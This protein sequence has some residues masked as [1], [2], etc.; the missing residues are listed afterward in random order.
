MRPRRRHLLTGLLALA[1]GVLLLALGRGRPLPAEPPVPAAP[2]LVR[3]AAFEPTEYRIRVRT[4]GTVA[5]RTESDL[6]AE[7]AGRVVWASSALVPGGFFEQGE[8]LLEVD[9]RD[10][11]N[12]VARAR[13][14]R[15]RA[16]SEVDLAALELERQL[17]LAAREIAS[18]S[19]LE[20]ARNSE[21]VARA[22]LAEATAQ[23]ERARRDL[24]RT[25][26][27]APFV[28]RVRDKRVD[29]GQFV[30]RGT[31]IARVYAVDFAEVRL[32][33]HDADLAFLDLPIGYR[34][35]TDPSDGPE[36]RLRASFAGRLHRWHARVVRTE[37]EIDATTRMLHLVAR[38]ED[39]YGRRDGTPPLAVGLFVEAEIL[40]RMLEEVLVLPRSAVREDG[41]LLVVDG[42]DRLRVRTGEILRNE[43]E[44]TVVRAALAS[45]ERVCLSRVHRPGDGMLVRPVADA[46]G[47]G[48]SSDPLGI[49][50]HRP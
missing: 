26:V 40:G 42:Q 25:R 35:E 48:A 46:A 32:P 39:P 15:A 13:A 23:L 21:R 38:V 27:L 20:R 50:Q 9:R 30:A 24:E 45:G 10:Y 2:R 4:H 49:A 33:V 11:A 44:H 12:A 18:A 37:G 14:R 29:I 8:R 19:D 31:P 22:A 6:V 7:V 47:A 43:G 5:P 1:G 16:Q 3:V 34:G 41:S 28:G 36:V 17:A